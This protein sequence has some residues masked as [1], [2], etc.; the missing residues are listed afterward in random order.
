MSLNT[1][2]GDHE[3]KLTNHKSVMQKIFVSFQRDK[4]LYFM[5]LLGVVWV[6]V[7]TYLP[8][9]GILVAFKR[10]NVVDGIWNSPWVGFHNFRMFFENPFFYRLIEN[11]FLLGLLSLIWGFW[12]PILLALLL[13]ELRQKLFKRV[14]QTIS[15]LPHFIAII[16]IVGMMKEF[17]SY[18]GI[19][20]QIISF[21]GINTINFFSEPSWF[22]PLYIGSDIWQTIGFSSIIYLAV[23][24]SLNP[25]LYESAAMEGANR[26]QMAMYITIPSILPTIMILFILNTTSIVNVGFEKVFLMYSPG[27]YETADVIATFTYRIGIEG[28][29]ISFG[30]AVGL[31]NQVIS[32]IFVIATNYISRKTTEYS[33]W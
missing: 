9:Y 14:V 20:N 19:V 28:G 2:G 1:F 8:A 26:L 29:Q 16:I 5:T 32:L 18:R 15:Y 4:Y 24:S 23:L 17:F 10:F 22:R 12:P 31:F 33:M 13:N 3:N 6:F 21:F 7:F 30:A 25:E 11:T 27:I